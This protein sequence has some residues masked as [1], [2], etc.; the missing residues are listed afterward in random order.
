[1]A[2]AP[3]ARLL[4][5]RQL[6]RR[7]VELAATG[8]GD[9]WVS[10][11]VE[12]QLHVL[13]AS[14][15]AQLPRLTLPLL[16]ALGEE[17]E[18][19]ARQRPKLAW[20]TLAL[21][22]RAAR[23]AKSP[24]LYALASWHVARA[25]NEWVRP[26]VVANAVAEA[27]PLFRRLGLPG[28][29]AACIWQE[30]ALPWTRPSFEAARDALTH[31]LAELEAAAVDNPE[32]SL[33]GLRCRLDLAYAQLLTGAY[34]AAQRDVER[35][36][37]AFSE[38]G[39]RL[40]LARCNFV[41]AALSY[42]Q[43]DVTSA[44][45]CAR[46]GLETFESCSS[47]ADVARATCQIAIIESK[48]A[49]EHERTLALLD[50]AE[51]RFTSLD[52]PLWIAQ[53]QHSK[54][55][56]HR[57]LGHLEV[58]RSEL[59]GART[60]YEEFDIPGLMADAF[61]DSGWVEMA[62]G[63]VALSRELLEKALAA[64]RRIASPLG[65]ALCQ[66]HLGD[67]YRYMGRYQQALTMLEQAAATFSD[68]KQV[69]SETECNLRLATV[70]A[71]LNDA[72]QADLFLDRA[73][74]NVGATGQ[75][76]VS[77]YIQLRR[78]ATR[79]Q[80]GNAEA[81]LPLLAEADQAAK[82]GENRLLE[83]IVQ[84]Q[85]GA[86][87]CAAGRHEET[88]PYLEAA[89]KSF[90]EMGLPE[91]EAA[92]ALA[93]ARYHEQAGSAS[94]A[95]RYYRLTLTHEER[96]SPTFVWQ[97]YDGLAQQA[98]DSGNLER[99]LVHYERAVEA[100]ARLRRWFL[101]PGLA[102]GYLAQPA[103]MLERAI[104][105]GAAAAQESGSDS[106]Q[107]AERVLRFIE[108]AKAGAIANQ[109]VQRWADATGN[110]WADG[111]DAQRSDE[112]RSLLAAE[113]AWL[114]HRLE[115]VRQADR[116]LQQSE[117]EIELV[118]QLQEKI[119]QFDLEAGRLERAAHSASGGA[120]GARFSLSAFR[121][122]AG[123]ALGEKWVALD[124]YL[125]DQALTTVLITAEEVQVLS[126]R[127]TPAVRIALRQC[128]Q[129]AQAGRR[130]PTR[131]LQNVGQWLFPGAVRAH[132]HPD[133]PLL[134]APH[135]VLHRLPWAGLIP[136]HSEQPLVYHAIPAIVPSLTTLRLLWR[137]AAQADERA[138][139]MQGG[140]LLAISDFGDRYPSLPEVRR[141]A[142]GIGAH[143]DLVAAMLI[144]QQASWP[145]L[146]EAAGASGLRA[147]SFLHIASHAFHDPLSGR[148]SGIALADRDV[149]LDDLWQ[150]A[151]L[152]PLVTLA[153]CSGT[154]SRVFPGDEH[155]GLTSTCLTAGAGRVVGSLRPVQ[156]P[157]A[158][159][160]MTSFYEHLAA[161]HGAAGAL[162]S[163]GRVAAS[164]GVP[165]EAWA[166]FIC[167]GAP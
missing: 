3:T 66:M 98:A 28:W 25:G 24:Q 115:V 162:A 154:R 74:T 87:L 103:L 20:L 88:P 127:R 152:P 48:R 137:R 123:R 96:I 17:A 151:P 167:V 130:L 43:G 35:C 104:S 135:G 129:A 63:N 53:C 68:L 56:V 147:F 32:F 160:F 109:L 26:Q 85:M 70:W 143:E 108:T 112:K 140:L 21:A 110:D 77:A 119:A 125:S 65:A 150:C 82:R 128:A 49:L 75:S 158:A 99:A 138:M 33:F 4:P 55:R 72:E 71:T 97:A 14:V 92:T 34:E 89:S 60:I 90:R 39:D 149:L 76:G 69:G 145:R 23:Q 144:D 101:Q 67:V 15:A 114:R 8:E 27:L 2:H 161:G 61:L 117:E 52:L 83:S 116:R 13:P 73:L 58:A 124:Y 22:Q 86:A 11:G 131:H 19:L 45:A 102:G 159:D 12:P 141:E 5:Y 81:A 107:A 139:P 156:D 121:A 18:G 91:E 50:E 54:A 122:A 134:I 41:Q 132:L 1:M 10:F 40:Y 78:A 166:S 57:L 80:A 31:A 142:K 165:F 6:A 93:W 95:G 146:Q 136:A 84:R 106:A 59:E 113:I 36:R 62:F 105:L 155:M 44:L 120:A 46:D 133:T 94:E 37:V 38:S 47:A 9:P 157:H 153:A 51:A 79:L 30:N 7:V 111:D 16:S 164:C 29:V 42:R 163:A 148:Y 118:R 100:L 126:R 64:N